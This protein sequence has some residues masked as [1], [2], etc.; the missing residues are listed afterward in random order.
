MNYAVEIAKEL[1][2]R[3]NPDIDEAV[4]GEIISTDPITISLFKGQII[5]TQGVN[6]YVCENLKGIT[7]T[8]NL[9]SVADHGTISTKFAITR[10]LNINDKVLCIP[11]SGG[12][13]Y[14]IID[15]VVG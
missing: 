6:C 2:N 7:G 13:K 5:C 10:E 3:D 9:E 15:K 11:T 4:I 14:F 1:K 12:K 8:I